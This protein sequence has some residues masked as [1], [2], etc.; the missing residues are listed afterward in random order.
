MERRKQS[1]PEKQA[2]ADA[3]YREIDELKEQASTEE[4]VLD[5]DPAILEELSKLH[6]PLGSKEPRRG[7]IKFSESEEDLFTAIRAIGRTGDRSQR[8]IMDFLAGRGKVVSEGT[9]K[10]TLAAL[11]RHGL[12]HGYALLGWSS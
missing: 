8:A 4:V 9:T 6:I 1:T 5:Y 7:P 2:I 11:V 3:L 10:N 12:L